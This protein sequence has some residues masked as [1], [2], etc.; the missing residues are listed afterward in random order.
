MDYESEIFQSKDRKLKTI[1]VPFD[2]PEEYQSDLRKFR[3]E[4]N[5]SDNKIVYLRFWGNLAQE[6]N[7]YYQVNDYILI[8]GYISIEKETFKS[9]NTNKKKII[10]TGLK[11]YPFLLKSNLDNKK[12]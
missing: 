5:H 6:V 12:V 4:Y 1:D 9:V 7:N 11:I 3:M 2:N 8:E 10:I